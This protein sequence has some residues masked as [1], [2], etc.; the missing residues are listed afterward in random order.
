M[1]GGKP[2]SSLRSTDTARDDRPA[3]FVGGHHSGYQALATCRVVARG[4]PSA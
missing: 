2:S 3:I 1:G 4:G